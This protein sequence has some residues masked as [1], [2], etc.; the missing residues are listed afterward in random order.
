MTLNHLSYGRT[1]RL[2]LALPIMLALWLVL[3]PR[4]MGE[5][6]SNNAAN[7]AI[8]APQIFL[9]EKSELEQKLSKLTA[10]KVAQLSEPELVPNSEFQHV[11]EK[12][13]DG[14]GYW[15]VGSRSA[16][17][18]GCCS[19]DFR[20][21]RFHQRVGCNPLVQRSAADFQ[22]WLDPGIPIMVMIHGSFVNWELAVE[23]A[24]KTYCWMRK[25]SRG[26]PI[27]MVFY[28]WPS[29]APRTYIAAIDI[30]L[31]GNHADLNGVSLT[32]AMNCFPKE[33]P[34]CV[35]GHSHGCRVAASAMHLIGGGS[36]KGKRSCLRDAQGR[37]FRLIF[38]AAAFDHPWL[39]PGERFGCALRP[40]EGFL[41]LRNRHDI[42]LKFYRVAKP[43]SSV[44]FARSGF[45]NR[46]LDRLGW[47]AQK[48][49]EIDVA[50]YIGC[51]HTWPNYYKRHEIAHMISPWVYF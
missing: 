50:P 19:S 21:L 15:I 41:N 31:F 29:D 42:A 12:P 13:F 47:L 2:M 6:N 30:T 24:H 9:N 32:N 14:G 48:V 39:N 40:V 10:P 46:D 51:R 17:P 20:N 34:V 16:K 38:A 22:E 35:I 8:P 11:Q 25:V 44:Q 3:M 28:T 27:R 5:E 33:S 1:A 23:D 45:S 49:R 4:V 43:L 26:R 37:R 36:I 7:I 18:G